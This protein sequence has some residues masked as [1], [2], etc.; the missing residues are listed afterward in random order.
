MALGISDACSYN[1]APGCYN[2]NSGTFTVNYTLNVPVTGA[3]IPPSILLTL[4][5]LACGAMYLGFNG[6]RARA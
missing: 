3:P 6:L 2:D 5:G 1:G 4:I